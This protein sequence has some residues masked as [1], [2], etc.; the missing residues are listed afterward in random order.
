M[1]RPF[2][3]IALGLLI[4]CQGDQTLSAYG[5]AGRRWNLVELDGVAAAGLVTLSFPE[6]GRVAGRT[7]CLDFTATQTAPYP[8]FEIAGLRSTP[9][10]CVAGAGE[11]AVLKALE[12]MTLV[13]VLGGVLIL[14][15]DA[16][17]EMVF[18]AR[19]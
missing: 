2:A 15:N 9:R 14:R 16:G 17:R 5:A 11:L 12:G 1:R 19:G 18:H 8:W 7:D 4:A 6:P 3:I 13:E 10:D